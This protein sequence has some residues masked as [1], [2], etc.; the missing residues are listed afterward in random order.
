MPGTSV[1]SICNMALA[2][3]G[4][5]KSITS[6]TESS[7][8]AATCSA[9]YEQVRDEVLV[10]FPWPF[11]L[12]RVTLALVASDPNEDWAYSYRRP[13]DCLT[14]RRVLAGTSRRSKPLVWEPGG[15]DAGGLVFTDE[16]EAALEY[17]ARVENPA[18]FP[19]KFVNALAWR[20]AMELA[21]VLQ[22]SP[23]YADVAERK[24]KDA[25]AKATVHAANEGVPDPEG[26]GTFIDARA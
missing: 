16:A 17:V 24:Y 4:Q 21:P 11:A 20:L 6:L 2:R 18:V 5:G 7:Q 19:P 9:F 10:E 12:R 22:E 8:A 14:A 25:L 23:A 26:D 3:I 15:D 1:V 13:T